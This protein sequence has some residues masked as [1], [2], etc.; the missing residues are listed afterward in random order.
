MADDREVL[1]LL[2]GDSVPPW[3]SGE[4]VAELVAGIATGEE[5]HLPMNLPNHGQV[6]NLPD[7]VVVECIGVT[8]A[9]GVRPRDTAR[10]GSVLGEHLRQI[11]AS[12]ELTVDAALT[13]DHT[14]VVEAMLT[15]QLAGHLPYEQL[16]AMTEELLAAT[17]PWLPTFDT[18]NR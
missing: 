5:R 3:P 17:A 6:E 18:T 1:E 16:L 11:V 10:V 15:D 14:R 2:K 12:Q 9:S 7:D 13:G 8:G 4:L